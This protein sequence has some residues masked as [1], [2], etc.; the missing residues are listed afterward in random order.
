MVEAIT[1]PPPVIR[2]DS[3]HS[4]LDQELPNYMTSTHGISSVGNMSLHDVNPPAYQEVA[5]G[6][7]PLAGM[8]SQ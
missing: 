8:P 6:G 7:Q 1:W 3:R 2:V 5:R 4:K